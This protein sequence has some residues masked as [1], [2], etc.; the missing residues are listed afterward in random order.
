MAQWQT[1]REWHYRDGDHVGI[2]YDRE[3]GLYAIRTIE[4]GRPALSLTTDYV[5]TSSLDTARTIVERGQAVDPS[6]VR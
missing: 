4:D 5:V 6:S 2:H 3:R 1:D